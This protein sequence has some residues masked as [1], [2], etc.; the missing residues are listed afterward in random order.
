MDIK[1]LTK[2]I[3][4]LAEEKKFGSKP[5]EINVGEKIAL[6]HSELSEALDAYRKKRFEGS[7]NFGEELADVIIRTLHLA[8]IFEID[9]EKEIMQKMKLNKDRVWEWD[10]INEK[11]L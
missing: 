2:I 4:D 8:G 9:I 11:H 7:D 10:K 5:D 6:I 1:D 3:L